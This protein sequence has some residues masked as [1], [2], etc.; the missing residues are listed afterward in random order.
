MGRGDGRMGQEGVIHTVH[1]SYGNQQSFGITYL[2][3]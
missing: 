1:K 2:L 3:S